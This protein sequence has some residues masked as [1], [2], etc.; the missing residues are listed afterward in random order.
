MKNIATWTCASLCMMATLILIAGVTARADEMAQGTRTVAGE[1]LKIT[2]TF[3]VVK[4][5][6][7]KGVLEV[8]SDTVVV[9]DD[10]GQQVALRVSKDTKQDSVI[11]A[12]DQIEASVKP[13]GQIVSIRPAK[14]EAPRP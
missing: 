3:S 8:A 5:P 1:V 10:K 13:D 6:N 7:G 12:G 14:A 2:G 4:G 9:Q 11:D